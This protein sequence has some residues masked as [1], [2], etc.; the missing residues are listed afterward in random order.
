MKL[1]HAVTA[2]LMMQL[3]PAQAALVTVD[4]PAGPSTAVLDTGTGLEWLKF[5][6]TNNASIDQVFSLT[7]PGGSLG[8]FHYASQGEFCAFFSPNAGLGCF[9]GRSGDVARVQSFLD[10]FDGPV[11]RD[12]DSFVSYFQIDPPDVSNRMGF[13][14]IITFYA[15]PLPYFETDAQLVTMGAGRLSDPAFHWLVRDTREVPEPATSALA[16]LGVIA[17]AC[18]RIGRQGGRMRRK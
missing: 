2:V 7:A 5:S 18:L 17:L 3:A 16:G 14:K 13:G 6:A 15:E 12:A 1:I 4:S 10:L 8:G 9:T 11:L